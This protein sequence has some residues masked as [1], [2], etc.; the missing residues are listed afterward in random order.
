ME[1][2]TSNCPSC[3]N[4]SLGEIQIVFGDPHSS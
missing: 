2:L 4:N 3:C 1:D